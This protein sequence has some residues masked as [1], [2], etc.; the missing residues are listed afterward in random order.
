[1]SGAFFMSFQQIIC[2]FTLV[3]FCKPWRTVWIRNFAIKTQKSSISFWITQPISHVSFSFWFMWPCLWKTTS[4]RQNVVYFL[5]RMLCYWRQEIT[6]PVLLGH[7][8]RRRSAFYFPFVFGLY[9]ILLHPKL[10][11][12]LW[13]TDDMNG[14]GGFV[15]HS[16]SVWLVQ[17]VAS[18]TQ[19]DATSVFSIWFLW[20]QH[21][22]FE[23]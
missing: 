10:S 22:H 18:W 20:I 11:T 23:Y 4:E 17:N 12:S 5:Y 21:H 14:S 8:Q 9:K 15:V 1:M 16:T 7:S 3:E 2:V 13:L 6:V 19:W